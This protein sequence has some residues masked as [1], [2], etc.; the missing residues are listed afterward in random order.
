MWTGIN[1]NLT[2]LSSLESYEDSGREM[3]NGAERPSTIPDWAP[4]WPQIEV[5][6][7]L[8]FHALK[9]LTQNYEIALITSNV[10]GFLRELWR[11][12]LINMYLQTKQVMHHLEVRSNLHDPIVEFDKNWKLIRDPENQPVDSAYEEDSLI[13]NTSP[14]LLDARINP[15]SFLHAGETVNQPLMRLT[16]ADMEPSVNPIPW[17]RPSGRLDLTTEDL[18]PSPMTYRDRPLDPRPNVIRELPPNLTDA[19]FTAE[20]LEIMASWANQA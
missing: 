12:A 2:D 17:I 8:G 5:E 3:C 6:I 15:D 16:E 1:A 10:P 14:Q 19:V 20:D 11:R 7:T 4:Y 13:V 18:G 9:M